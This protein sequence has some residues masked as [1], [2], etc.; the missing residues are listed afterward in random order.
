M[1]RPELS[2]RQA[3]LTRAFALV[4]S[5]AY[6]AC[7]AASHVEPPSDASEAQRY[8]R[9]EAY[10]RDALER[11]LTSRAN[12]YA[13]RR[14]AHFA[15][16]DRAWDLVPVYD[17]PTAALTGA[18]IAELE[19]GRA[20]SLGDARALVGELAP[21]SDGAALV[22]LGRD[23]FLTMPLKPDADLLATLASPS[24]RAD[25]GLAPDASGAYVGIRKVPL[26]G[27]GV[28]VAMTCATCH[29]DIVDGV[30]VLGRARRAIHIGVIRMAPFRGTG[31]EA[32]AARVLLSW[33]AQREDVTDDGRVNPVRIPDIDVARWQRHFDATGT[34][35]S[36]GFGTLAM[37]TETL[38]TWG[39]GGTWRPAR[40]LAA[41]IAAFVRTLGPDARAL[42]DGPGADVFRARCAGCHDPSRG[43]TSDALIA[44]ADVGTDPAVGSSEDRG[45]GYY[46]VPSLVGIAARAP[47]LH[48]ASAKT[49]GDVLSR[50]HAGHPFA[51]D[52]TDAERASLLAVLPLL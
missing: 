1:R 9:D 50:D 37:R 39:S 41:A 7:S 44:V 3:A 28:G 13:V 42:P 38:V 15:G 23:A 51:P 6:A 11:S 2:R 31:F 33:G 26:D 40:A 45:T 47:Y 14:L 16:G 4:A 18:D 43:F 20:L 27:G 49:L 12:A 21:A 48:D 24:A 35:R 5:F 52:M 8:V 10:R 32:D 19:A 25:S 22:A 34:L 17:P 36:D 46:R 29:A 30:A